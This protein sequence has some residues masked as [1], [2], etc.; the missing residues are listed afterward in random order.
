MDLIFNKILTIRKTDRLLNCDWSAVYTA[1]VPYICTYSF[2]CCMKTEQKNAPEEWLDSTAVGL[3][4]VGKMSS[5]WRSGTPRIYWTVGQNSLCS[6]L[7]LVLFWLFMISFDEDINFGGF[8]LIFYYFSIKL[9][10]CYW[11]TKKE[12]AWHLLDK[13]TLCTLC[14]NHAQF[15]WPCPF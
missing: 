11:G 8:W 9:N 6:V 4:T 13:V 12:T 14:L 2:L 7:R 1:R 15:C 5:T 3:H 10:C